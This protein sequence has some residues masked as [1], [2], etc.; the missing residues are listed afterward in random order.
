M[1]GAN[2]KRLDGQLSNNKMNILNKVV[3]NQVFNTLTNN[4]P[5]ADKIKDKINKQDNK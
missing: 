4:N 1:S 5:V 3:D 2:N